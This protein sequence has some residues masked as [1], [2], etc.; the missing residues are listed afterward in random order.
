M[1]KVLLPILLFSIFIPFL[2]DAETCNP[3]SIILESIELSTTSGNAEEVREASISDKKINLDLKL[4]DPGDSVEC[5][6]IV[7]NTSNEDFYFD[8]E[9][10]KLNTDYLEYEFSYEDNSNIIEAGKEKIIKL[11]V[12]YKNKVPTEVLDNDSFNDINTMIVNLSNKS[13]TIENP[14]TG[15]QLYIFLSMFLILVS[16]SLYVILKNKKYSKYMMLITG[17]TI[18]IPMSVYA[19]CKVNIEIEAKIQIDRKEAYFLTGTEV[20]IKMKQLAGNNTST[21]NEETVDTNITSIKYSKNEPENFEKENKNIVSTQDSPYPIYMWYDNGTIYWWS[22]DKTPS[23]N[24]DA[25]KMFTLMSS[26]TN[27]DGVANFDT[28]QTTNMYGI[29]RGLK[30]SPMHISSIKPLK[31]WNTSNVTNMRSLFQSNVALESIEGLEKWDVS[32]VV[33]M[34][35]IFSRCRNLKLLKSLKNW[36]T[37]NVTNMRASFSDLNSLTSLN[38]LE[39]W[40][41]SKVTDMYTLFTAGSGDSLT[42]ELNNI[43][44]L[45]NWNVSNVTDMTAIFQNQ[46][47]L[48]NINALSNWNTKNVEIFRNFCSGCSNLNNVSALYN[49]DTSNATDMYLM[50]NSNISLKEVDISNW[51]LNKLSSTKNANIFQKCTGLEKIKTPKVYPSDVNVII[52][53]P[54]TLYDDNNNSY[55]KLDNT[56]PTETWLKISN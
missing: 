42:T 48:T 39:N 21:D 5:N 17:I 38:G 24:E 37:S 15:V 40:D 28:L 41:V 50:F 26:L 34:S 44:A 12:E 30:I 31:N 7:K 55:T 33:D 2:V 52:N 6:L 32:R 19:L 14:K 10:S 20:N 4:Y 25:S 18:I 35:F 45:K 9:S 54:V 43:D 36:D 27:I 13:S 16:G 8:E 46:K 22:E 53:L 11:R 1:R 23:L 47:K 3:T 49:W 56:S 51:N 29:F